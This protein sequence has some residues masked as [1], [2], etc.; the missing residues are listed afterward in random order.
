MELKTKA[1]E[2]VIDDLEKRISHLEQFQHAAKC[3]EIANEAN[4]KR[5]NLL[6]HGLD[7]N[8]VWEKKE[9]DLL[10]FKIFLQEGLN[11]NLQD[12]NII[13]IHRLSQWPISKQG[14]R[15]IRPIIAKLSNFFEKQQILSACKFL[16]TF[17]DIRKVANSQSVYVTEHLPK[18]FQ[19]QKNHYFRNSK[20]PKWKI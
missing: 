6:I 18:L 13:D 4:S 17:N 15:L 1:T 12:I 9:T 5:L 11:L 16:K 8:D 19:E 10:I 7:E 3:Q 2:Q 14:K 20:K